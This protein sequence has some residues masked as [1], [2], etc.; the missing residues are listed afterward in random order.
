MQSAQ[1]D[2]AAPRNFIALF[3][4]IRYRQPK[5]YTAT[6][7]RHRGRI[8]CVKARISFLFT[9]VLL[10]LYAGANAQS[11]TLT[12]NNISLKELLSR[13][14]QQTGY[15]VFYNRAIL[16]NALPVT[17]SVKNVPLNEFLTMSLKDQPVDFSIKEGLKVINLT[18]KKMPQQ[19]IRKVDVRGTVVDSSGKPLVGATVKV[20]G[21]AK[22]VTVNES[23]DFR[24]GYVDDGATLIISYLGYQTQEVKVKAD[25]LVLHIVMLHNNNNLKEVIINTGYEKIDTRNLTSAVTTLKMEDIKVAGINTVDKMLEGRVPGM[26]FMQN[27]GQVGAAPKIKIRG[28]STILGNQEPLWVLD[29]IV[30]TSPVNISPSQINDLDFVNLLGNAISGLNPDDIEQID[31]LKDAAATALYGAKA[32]NGVIVITSKKGK[33][34]SPT[35]TYSATGTFSTRPRYSDKTINLMNS[36]ERIDVSREMIERNM[37]YNNVSN[38]TGYEAA[39]QDYYSGKIDFDEYKKTI[40]YYESI[41]T[42]WFKIVTRDVFS[43]NH[44]LSLSGGSPNVKYYASLGYTDEQGTIKSEMNRRYSATL[45]LTTDYKRFSTLFSLQ[46]NASKRDYNPSDLNVLDYAYKTSRTVPAYNADGTPWFYKRSSG[47]LSYDFNI[48]HEM[49]NSGD[50]LKSNG[51]NLNERIAYK[52]TRNWNV[53]ALLAY[54]LNNSNQEV[55][56]TADTYYIYAARGDGNFSNLAPIG[57]ELRETNT[58]NTSWTAR[59][60]SNFNQP[61]GKDQQH[62]LLTSAG[63]EFMST[64]Y[65]SFNIVRR[66]FELDR[67]KSFSYIPTSYSSY[68]NIWMRNPLAMGVLSDQLDNEMS[69]YAMA[70]YSHKDRYL[71]NIHMRAES[72][73][74]FGSQTNGRLLPIWALSGRWNMKQDML[75]SAS[76]L[77]D[78]ALRASWGYQG[79]M[80]ADQTPNM[81]IRKGV[82]NNYYNEYSSTVEHFPNADLKWEKIASSNVAV[83]F[84]LFNNKISGSVSYY[85]KKTMNAF[86]SKTVS[87]INGVDAYVVN[88]GTLTNQGFEVALNFTP[89][90]QANISGGKRGFVWRIDPQLGQVLNNLITKATNKRNNILQDAITYDDMLAGHVQLSGHPLNTFYSYRFKGLSNADGSPVFYGTEAEKAD[91]YKKQ[92]QGMKREDVYLAVMSE[93]GRRE[94][95]IQG[96][97]SNSLGYR[98]F[99][100]SFNLTYS[101]GNK[102]RLLKLT[103]DYGTVS[104]YPQDNLRKEFVYRWRKPGDEKYTNIPALVAGNSVSAPWWQ[105]SDAAAYTFGGNAY[106]MY[107]QSDIRVVSGD[108]VKLQSLSFRYNVDIKWCQ[109]LGMKSIYLNLT[110]SNLYTWAGRKLKGQDPMQSGST[111]SIQLSIRPNYSFNVNVTF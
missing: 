28:N 106:Q 74:L 64:R 39:I 34:G 87:D 56:Y 23:G 57:G 20:K 61:F 27:S 78:I 77:N 3:F 58:Q 60:Q 72:S 88:K 82:F 50:E 84:S 7:S 17:L 51:I 29:G 76:W 66:G 105:R 62:R 67:G 65:N 48:M 26:I 43:Q 42:D 53:E 83:D 80:L 73:N 111:P 100:L 107:D 92:Y 91:D 21:E 71:F 103:S 68:Y 32:G 40:D 31:I 38:W 63:I 22:G 6:G 33:T 49:D 11:V 89:I 5:D 44:T 30:L 2:A 102:I 99:S 37:Q 79:N 85:Y 36:R 101:V 54:S 55:Y 14:Q 75:K 9:I 90:N 16:D 104:P 59:L 108:Y 97:V 1:K 8:S 70:G 45:N 19:G 12:V 15:S 10:T 69:W 52:L 18:E 109:Q 86:L 110:G 81:I 94:P 98:N 35:F 93:S 41:N 13:V 4:R 47:Y 25:K 46:A 24:I 96:G 95:F